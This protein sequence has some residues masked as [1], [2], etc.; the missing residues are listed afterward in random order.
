MSTEQEQSVADVLLA[1][2]L[3]AFSD[4]PDKRLREI[5]T[6]LVRHLHAFA[7][8][9]DLSGEER[10]AAVAFLTA[11]GHK[12]DDQRQEFELLSD[13]LGL[14]SLVETS[15]TGEGATLQTLT[16][17]FYSPGAPW[18]EFGDSMNEY[19]L[20][21]DITAVVRGVVKDR[22]GNPIEGATLDVWQNATNRLYAVQDSNQ[23]PGN[24]RGRWKTGSDGRYQFITVKPVSYSIPDDGP[25]GD[26]LART[27][28]HPWRAAHIHFLVTADGFRPLT[29]EIF[30]AQSGYLEDD[31]VFGVAADLIV[32]FQPQGGGAVL[33]EFDFTLEPARS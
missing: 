16:G 7:R 11:V 22:E 27:N 25:V 14:S 10:S 13:V 12:C 28:R 30:D 15:T 32:D 33:G 24:L 6:L 31:A 20:P 9:A 8:E 3:A 1:Q 23:P 4:T 5:M 18:R 26:L 2:V 29:T 21:E 19:P 17:P